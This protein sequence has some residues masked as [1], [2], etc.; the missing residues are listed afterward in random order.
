MKR[1]LRENDS[2]TNQFVLS[3]DNQNAAES[4]VAEAAGSS[5]RDEEKTIFIVASILLTS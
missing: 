3:V 5:P 4:F 1:Q 2:I